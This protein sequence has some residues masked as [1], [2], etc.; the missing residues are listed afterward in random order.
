MY[1][2]IYIYSRYLLV[3]LSNKKGKKETSLLEAW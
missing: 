2:Y 1:I 3:K